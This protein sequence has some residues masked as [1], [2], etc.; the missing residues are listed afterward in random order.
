M[1]LS[2]QIFL[3]LEALERS[4]FCTADLLLNNPFFW[5]V[6][7]T[8]AFFDTKYH[9]LSVNYIFLSLL[10]PF[11]GKLSPSIN[12][13]DRRTLQKFNPVEQLMVF[14]ALP[15]CTCISSAV[16][17]LFRHHHTSISSVFLVLT[18]KS[19]HWHIFN[20]R[21]II[22]WKTYRIQIESPPTYKEARSVFHGHQHV[23]TLLPFPSNLTN[24]CLQQRNS[25]KD[26]NICSVQPSMVLM[27][28]FSRITDV[29][30][31]S[32]RA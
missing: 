12:I 10:W 27:L 13:W 31:Y 7:N 14:T 15:W 16:R 9:A 23:R 26:V 19:W 28:K 2:Q 1:T 5:G 17:G 25:N 32:S 3:N 6:K 30:H 24:I 20:H 4:H 29:L 22:I 18:P 21:I 8:Q 11:Q